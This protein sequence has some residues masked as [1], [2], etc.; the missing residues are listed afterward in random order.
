MS[1]VFTQRQPMIDFDEKPLCT[2]RV[3]DPKVGELLAE[4]LRIIGE[5]GENGR[6]HRAG[7]ESKTQL[8]ARAR[9]DAAQSGEW[10][11]TDE[12]VQLAFGEIAT[13]E[14]G[15][16]GTTQAKAAILPGA[17]GPTGAEKRPNPSAPFIAG[18]FAAIEAGLLGALQ[19]QAKATVSESDASFPSVTAGPE[20]RLYQDNQ[21]A[22]Q[23]D[24]LAEARKRSRRTLRVMLAVAL[25]GMAGT[26][27][28]FG[29]NSRPPAPGIP[30]I[31]ADDGTNEWQ[32]EPTTG[33]DVPA[34]DSPILSELPEPSPRVLVNGNEQTFD[35]P[36]SE[37]KTLAAASQVQLDNGASAAPRVP[38]QAPIPAEPVGT[39]APAELNTVKGDP[40]PSDGSLA[41]SGAPPQANINEALPA[42]PSPAAT[43]APAATAPEPVAKPQKPTTAKHRIHHGQPRQIANKAKP[44]RRS[45]LPIEPAPSTG[46]AAQSQTMQPS[47]ET[48]GALGFLQSAVKSL[49]SATAKL[50]GGTN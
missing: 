40:V 35:V 5:T 32:P 45:P 21:P 24:S 18:D 22:P 1:D 2:P 8:P 25:V 43:E 14:P 39:A 10:K 26:I 19:D 50:F 28:I 27:V 15:P 31:R 46:P 3:T 30:S 11:Q 49:T 29:L 9:R 42:S 12:Q 36:Q 34:Q 37:E 41:A 33:A 17:H 23:R 13:I 16:D 6:P 47:Q 44:T 7:F 48:D 38:A 20:G 4:L